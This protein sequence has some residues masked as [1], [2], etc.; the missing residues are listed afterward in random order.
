MQRGGVEPTVTDAN[1]LLQRLNP[2]HLLGGR[3]PISLDA[4]REAI[5][6]LGEQVGLDPIAMAGG[7]LTLT[8]AN[9]VHAIRQRTIERGLDPRDFAIVAYGGAGPLHATNVASELGIS[10]VLV[11]RSPGVTSALGL[12]FAD[13]RHDFVATV[14]KLVGEVSPAEIVQAYGQLLGE[15]RARLE[16]EGVPSERMAFLYSMDL[17]YEGQTHELAVQLPGEYSVAMHD[18]LSSLLRDVHMREFGH[19]PQGDEP[20][21]IVNLR[22]ACLGQLGRPSFPEVGLGPE[23]RPR[24]ERDVFFDEGWVRTP[25]Y[26]RETIHAGSKLCGPAVMEQLDSTTVIPPGWGCEADKYGNLILRQEESA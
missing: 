19:A 4:A 16:N 1:V 23:P 3:V 2:L 14:L 17:R 10:A 11:P 26:D 22:V 13:I 15:G 21:E 8:S 25:I 24:E 18:R 5:A 7:I 20:I 9:I 6:R 12:L